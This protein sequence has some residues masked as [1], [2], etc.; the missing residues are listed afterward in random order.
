[1]IFPSNTPAAS[2]P[3]NKSSTFTVPFRLDT[4]AEEGWKAGLLHAQVPL[5]FYNVEADEFIAVETEGGTSRVVHPDEGVYTSPERLVEML[6]RCSDRQLFDLEWDAGFTIRLK[7]G[8]AELRFSP[9]LGR[10]VGMS[11]TV[12]QGARSSCK[13]FDPWINHK[14][15]LVSCSLVRPTQFNDRH[16][17]V[18]QTLVLLSPSFGGTYFNYFTPTD[19]VEIQGECHT[20][21]TFR[22]TDLDGAPIRFRSGTVVLGL[23][24]E[25]DSSGG[26]GSNHS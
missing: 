10:L 4:P 17:P 14:V 2:F 8:V 13:R 12:R 18:L 7:P 15:L 16:E 26:R 5:T 25:H 6:L 23:T 9:R 21:V 22:I 11:G 24:L 19:L 1:V 20:A 3:D